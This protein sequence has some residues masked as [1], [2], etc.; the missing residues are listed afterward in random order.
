MK[1]AYDSALRSVVRDEVFPEA[2]ADQLRKDMSI[3]TAVVATELSLRYAGER[4]VA[5]TES[6]PDV[7]S[8]KRD[9]LQGTAMLPSQTDE[10]KR[11]LSTFK[12]KGS[13]L[14]Y[15]FPSLN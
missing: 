11:D 9:V 13:K 3:S 2:V 10:L 6:G 15:S 7:P 14:S 5:W 1:E 8:L 12:E 4:N